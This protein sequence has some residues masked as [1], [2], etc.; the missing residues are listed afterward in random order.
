M[1]PEAI[2]TMRRLFEALRPARPDWPPTF[3][4]AMSVPLLAG[5]L[6][7]MARDPD[8]TLERERMRGNIGPRDLQVTPEFESTTP[9]VT[10]GEPRQINRDFQRPRQM[11]FRAFD[12]IDLKSRA[13]GEKPED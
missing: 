4:E 6:H 7:T 8:G 3:E 5:L 10:L 12:G 2:E 1:K 13:A 11:R 9:D